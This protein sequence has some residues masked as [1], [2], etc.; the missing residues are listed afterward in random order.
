MASHWLAGEPT[1]SS[2]SFSWLVLLI[3]RTTSPSTDPAAPAS[4]SG[5][6]Q[7]AN[8]TLSRR[9][10][11]RINFARMS[12]SPS[13]MT[14]LWCGNYHRCFRVEGFKYWSGLQHYL[15]VRER[16]SSML[17]GKQTRQTLMYP[18]LPWSW[19]VLQQTHGCGPHEHSWMH[20]HR[21]L[22]VYS[23]SLTTTEGL[24]TPTESA[25][26]LGRRTQRQEHVVHRL[27]GCS[28][29]LSEV[30]IELSISYRT[31][32]RPGS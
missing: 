28:R 1:F 6:I 3:P 18:P 31:N 21:G 12:G 15:Q 19:V 23:C 9:G 8:L 20:L 25:Y 4:R 2:P 10:Q 24:T 27:L 29:W 14:R 32:Y 17:H 5:A 30:Q 11:D 13:Y 22:V 7:V 16:A 26:A